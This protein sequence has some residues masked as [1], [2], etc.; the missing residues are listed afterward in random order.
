MRATQ[1]QSAPRVFRRAGGSNSGFGQRAGFTLIE[2][3]VVVA[4]VGILVAIL[5]PALAKAR[6]AAKQT[7]ELSTGQQLMRAYFSYANDYRGSVLPGYGPTGITARDQT[8]QAILGPVA[9]R[10]PWR[11]AP[12]LEYNFA[13]LY[14]DRALLERY[15]S[16][17]DYQYVVSLSPSLGINSD[18]VGGDR[19]N[20]IA[21]NTTLTARFG[22]FFIRKI[23]DA[24]NPSRLIVF[25]SARGV[26]PDGGVPVNGFHR[27]VSPRFF[28]SRW[29]AES[30]R[31]SLEPIEHGHV[32]PRFAGRAVVAH[33]DGHGEALTI[34]E[35]RDMRRWADG[36]TS[37]EWELRERTAGVGGAGAGGGDVAG[38][39]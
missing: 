7:R 36:A 38:G 1:L 3:L 37:P 33:L 10:Y 15:Q 25:G 5:L 39:N 17:T 29:S 12:Y 14:D 18:F 27:I 11:I 24:K 26:D 13:G 20:Q 34:D 28:S 4:I 31:M 6:D 16:R 21:F 8:G 22:A 23:D 9:W 2:L 35:L 32:H 30:F 19:D